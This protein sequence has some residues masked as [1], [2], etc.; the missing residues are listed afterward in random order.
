MSMHA[1]GV[2]LSRVHMTLSGTGHGVTQVAEKS[3]RKNSFQL[4]KH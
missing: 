2:S 3:R 1:V 4:G